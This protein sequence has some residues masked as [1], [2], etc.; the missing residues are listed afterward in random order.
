M[1]LNRRTKINYV[2]DI[3]LGVSFLLVFVAGII[4]F[5]GLV[6][7]FGIN[8]G[9]L[10]IALISTIHDWS[11]L[12]MGILVLIHLLLHWGWIVGTTKQVIGKGKGD[13]KT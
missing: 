6:K 1:A 2:V 11:G 13:D 4:K 12:T 3:G 5:P 7:V 10:P 9:D 8:F